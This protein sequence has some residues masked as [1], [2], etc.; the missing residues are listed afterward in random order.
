MEEWADYISFIGKLFKAI[1]GYNGQKNIELPHGFQVAER[2]AQCL[3]P[4]LPYGVHQK[5]L[6]LYALIFEL[7]GPDHLQ[8]SIWLP[9]LLPLLAY[10]SMNVKPPLIAIYEK[11][12]IPS[13]NLLSVLRPL[14]LA[15]LPGI[16][17][18]TSE[19]FNDA[20][21]L[22]EK[23]K[24]GVNDESQ[25][26][27]HLFLAIM[28]SSDR[29]L[30]AL[31]WC[32]RRLPS[33]SPSIALDQ[34]PDNIPAAY[35][36]MSFEAQMAITPESGLLIRSFCQ[37]LSDDQLLIQRGFLEL[38]VKNLQLHSPVLQ[39][40]ASTSDYEALL[41][42][43]CATVLRRDMSLNRRLWNWLLGP[44]P[45]PNSSSDKAFS[46]FDYFSKYALDALVR[47]LLKM[48]TKETS[49]P[50]E[51]T[52]P[53]KICLSILDRWEIGTAVVPHV[54]IPVIRSVKSF[55]S[56]SNSDIEEVLRSA[57]SFFDGIE[58][59]AIWSDC[60]D[61][62]VE[63]QDLDLFIYILQMFNVREEE[64]IV[65]HLPLMLLTLLIKNSSP[66]LF[67]ESL[68]FQACDILIDLIPER[69]FLPVTVDNSNTDL[70][71]VEIMNEISK[72][73]H[74]DQAEA[75]AEEDLKPPFD[76][77]SLT[78]LII[79]QACVLVKVK[80]ADSGKYMSLLARILLKIH[81]TDNWRE[82]GIV[83]LLLIDKETFSPIQLG[84]RISL[85]NAIV[86][87]LT[88]H[89][90]DQFSFSIIRHIFFYLCDIKGIYQVEAV[91][92]LWSLQENLGDKRVQS[93]L[94]TILV[95]P[96]VPY[97]EKSRSFSTLWY[98]SVD[99]ANF[100]VILAE[101]LFLYL[102]QTDLLGTDKQKR[103]L[104]AWLKRQPSKLIDVLV[105]PILS[106]E[107]NSDL[108]Q[109][110]YF[111]GTLGRVLAVDDELL[112]HFKAK[113]KDVSD[114][115]TEY[116]ILSETRSKQEQS[117]ECV[118]MILIC[119]P[120]LTTSEIIG[121][122]HKCMI[123]ND[124]EVLNII[125]Q[126]MH[127][128]YQRSGSE[129]KFRY[130]DILEYTLRGI[131]RACDE[132]NLESPPV[133]QWTQFL[134]VVLEYVKNDFSEVVTPVCTTLCE[135]TQR[136]FELLQQ[137][138]ESD[139]VEETDF[140]VIP[141]LLS[142]LEKVLNIA[143]RCISG[144]KNESSGVDE[145]PHLSRDDESG[146]FGN[147]IS[148]VFS[149][150]SPV[151]QAENAH[152]RYQSLKCFELVTQLAF[153]VWKWID[154]RDAP[155]RST[156]GDSIA[157]ILSKVKGKSRHLLAR[158]YQLE[159]LQLLE[160][161]MVI[162]DGSSSVFKL[163]HILDGSRPISTAP[164]LIESILSRTPNTSNQSSGPSAVLPSVFQ[165]SSHSGTSAEEA[166]RP[167]ASDRTVTEISQFEVVRFVYKY[168]S[169]LENDA[170]EEVWNECMGFI[171]EVAAS[172]QNFKPV[173]PG[174]LS[175]IAVMGL[176]VDSIKFGAQRRVRK[177]LSENFMKLLVYSLTRPPTLN[178]N[179]HLSTPGTPVLE[180]EK[181]SKL[182]QESPIPSASSSSTITL[183]GPKQ[184]DLFRVLE[185]TV[186]PALRAIVNEDS[187][188]VLSALSTIFQH[189][190]I[191]TLKSKTFPDGITP[192]TLDL[193]STII[194]KFPQ[195]T[196]IWKPVIGD[197]V[198]DN[199]FMLIGYSAIV[200]WMPILGKWAL[201]DK[202]RIRDYIFKISSYGSNTTL[203]N[204]SDQNKVIQA[205]LNRLALLFICSKY[206]T[207]DV[208]RA[209]I[210][211]GSWTDMVDYKHL[212]KQFEEL[213]TDGQGKLGAQI[214][215]CLRAIIMSINP[216]R[217]APIVT[218]TYHQ[219]QRVFVDVL[220]KNNKVSSQTLISAC[221]LL[222][223]VL[224]LNP[225]EF[226]LYDWLF[227][228]DSLDALLKKDGSLDSG[229]IDMLAEH[230][231]SSIKSPAT[232]EE[233]LPTGKPLLAGTRLND[234]VEVLYPFFQKAS[235]LAYENVYSMATPDLSM[236][237]QD[238]LKDL[239]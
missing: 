61:L 217:L 129:E 172:P 101:C 148:G 99:R 233:I 207:T 216:N 227:V 127:L 38:L 232:A 176:K 166:F 132:I 188:K 2:L 154:T 189:G 130:R 229:L 109:L 187:E 28:S 138:A 234:R 220:N 196:K 7:Q 50:A 228:T 191:P 197:V 20:L 150:E 181:V 192:L 85:F 72:Y 92:A 75:E 27:Q 153:R 134:I 80:E 65:N 86:P 211:G 158:I 35:H 31:V 137:A 164:H 156:S 143:N 13:P 155:T 224:V 24:D 171:K 22:I 124:T 45:D 142:G 39:V 199:R 179:N 59:L 70:G 36:S 44:E 77:A 209:R 111:V 40:I 69:A 94:A 177:D 43:A 5:A 175:I 73:Y 98:H 221:K 100:D 152:D 71:P 114:K 180:D 108:P 173:L 182:R 11:Y 56:S 107:F 47:G 82:D 18:E 63:Q 29:R 213:L 200:G 117:P 62:I 8:L 34:Y 46:R 210:D 32:S 12:I 162:D 96:R 126:A 9:G 235:M 54:L 55:D 147:V 212:T 128:I 84:G 58:S 68:W 53:Y 223:V 169:S 140:S 106:S 139:A 81:E 149:V 226:Q 146:F 193:I 51:K 88:E 49:D 141:C 16:D 238:L 97:A 165:H 205:N 190:I 17:D 186:L 25:F 194:N 76:M 133:I 168:L 37:G 167:V 115:I 145:S 202:E 103:A 195:S 170:I 120:L 48:I 204:W 33:F 214:F 110:F 215:C 15:V 91:K 93:A 219:L 90:I 163:I 57:S 237:L 174:I 183:S 118:Q 119:L 41:M 135:C 26:W 225:E 206:S 64:M 198:F 95:D 3:D 79:E 239:V 203:F 104:P 1:K 4:D 14:L 112:P 201:T 231:I 161:L 60:F 157:F 6:E 21:A 208:A 19:S 113:C 184:E 218:F 230:N 89:E 123:S 52:K 23:I 236:C 67:S 116:Y 136:K 78:R 151:A 30:G 66:G 122:V 159:T 121:V 74:Q 178:S 87:S 222:D 105:S 102:D 42:S 185:S 131:V 83:S 10:A 125:Q 144:S 160:C